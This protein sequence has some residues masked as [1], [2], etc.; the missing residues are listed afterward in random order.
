[1]ANGIVT[2]NREAFFSTIRQN[3]KTPPGGKAPRVENPM[4]GLFTQRETTVEDRRELRER[5][6]QEWTT[7]GGKA[8]NIKDRVELAQAIKQIIQ[9]R[10]LQ[11]A[12]CWDH[13]ELEKLKLE[14]IFSDTQAS[15][16]RWPL[17]KNYSDWIGKAAS[18]EAGIVWSDIA[19]AE[20]GTLVLP[21]SSPGQP[22]TVCVLPITLI[23]IFT[24]AQLVDGFTG[25]VKLF[26]ERY[27]TNLPTTT[28]FISGPS[29]TTDIEMVLTIG[30]HGS[31][32]V[33][34]LILDEA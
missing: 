10:Q 29:R 24:T 13:P 17:E 28:T 5:F 1:M 14:E 27:G 11:K 19:M 25:V 16:S 31:R 30:V 8:F 20:T 7:L 6:I 9:E 15:L 33:Y 26:K 34:A 32:Y 18:M 22:T 2:G 4:D 21:S 3:I 12:M 23:A